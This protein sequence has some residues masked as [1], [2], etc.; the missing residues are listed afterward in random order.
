[1]KVKIYLALPN[2]NKNPTFDRIQLSDIKEDPLSSRP[3]IF[4]DEIKIK[5]HTQKLISLLVNH[6]KPILLTS[7]LKITRVR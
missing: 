6:K 4:K 3:A 7:K 2:F 1:M 5:K